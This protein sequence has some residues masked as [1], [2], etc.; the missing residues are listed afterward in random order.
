MSQHVMTLKKPASGRLSPVLFCA[1]AT[2][3]AE[4][5]FAAASETLTW[6]PTSGGVIS[7]AGN[8]NPEQT[9]AATSE[10]DITKVQSAPITLTDDFH[11]YA[12]KLSSDSSGA[13]MVV[14]MG[15]HEY[16]N[17]YS[18]DVSKNTVYVFTNGTL[19]IATNPDEKHPSSIKSGATLAFRGTETIYFESNLVVTG[20][21]AMGMEVDGTLAAQSALEVANGAKFY[22]YVGNAQSLRVKQGSR[23]TVTNRSEMVVVTDQASKA[24]LQTGYSAGSSNSRFE[25]LDHSKLDFFGAVTCG[26]TVSTTNGL[27]LVDGGSIVTNK[28]LGGDSILSVAGTNNTLRITN[29]SVVTVPILQDGAAVNTCSS[30][31]DVDGGSILRVGRAD[32]DSTGYTG[33]LVGNYE[34]GSGHRLLVRNGSKLVS[35]TFCYIGSG[36]DATHFPH[37]C[38]MEIRD[39]SAEF[40]GALC[41]GGGGSSNSL[42]LVNSTI[43]CPN[44]GIGIGYKI[45]TSNGNPYSG[46]ASLANKLDIENSTVNARILDVNG[47]LDAAGIDGPKAVVR[48]AGT[49]S[50]IKTSA[51]SRQAKF[52]N[53]EL[54][55][56]INPDGFVQTLV[57]IPKI[58]M[59][60]NS[61]V[62]VVLPARAQ[63]NLGGTKITLVKTEANQ[64]A[65]DETTTFTYPAELCELV[66]DVANG[67][68]Y[69]NVKKL[70]GLTLFVR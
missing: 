51:T 22:R 59:A 34:G 30:L 14:D 4:A 55:F 3:A 50:V 36:R 65:V 45:S 6:K 13:E 10:V 54:V 69:I 52:Y 47:Y 12:T 7:E 19:K 28:D 48:V 38:S 58:N 66:K 21:L 11:V 27:F 33:L 18:I 2:C 43:S 15:G 20:N 61:V 5:A 67:E 8:W 39:S 53:T 46:S 1:I 56:D 57:D 9:P 16:L 29:G 49:N 63:K 32:P 41:V 26:A 60:S 68:I 17:E 24:A 35:D 25:L 31:V 44:R 64:L 23:I 42:V 70:P 62:K 40:N 37:Q